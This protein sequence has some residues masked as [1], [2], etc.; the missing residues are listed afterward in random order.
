LATKPFMNEPKTKVTTVVANPGKPK[1]GTV[2]R[3]CPGQITR[4][5]KSCHAS[6]SSRTRSLLQT[7]GRL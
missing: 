7:K 4:E 2:M 1:M 6:R 3:R 5:T